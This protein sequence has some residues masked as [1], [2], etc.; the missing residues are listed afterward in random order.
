MLPSRSRLSA[1]WGPPYYPLR[2]DSDVQAGLLL[3]NEQNLAE[4]NVSCGFMS[5]QSCQ[6]VCSGCE[7]YIYPSMKCL[8]GHLSFC[9]LVYPSEPECLF[10]ACLQYTMPPEASS[11]IK[12]WGWSALRPHCVAHRAGTLETG[13][14]TYGYIIVII[15]RC[16]I[17]QIWT[18]IFYPL[19]KWLWWSII[20]SCSFYYS[21][22]VTVDLL[23]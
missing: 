14:Y 17:K 3:T 9:Q 18:D 4:S 16:V 6:P 15:V 12:G 8:T 10:S 11:Y 22:F 7:T 1:G 19:P 13:F 2:L 5:N 20:C 21:C 23:I